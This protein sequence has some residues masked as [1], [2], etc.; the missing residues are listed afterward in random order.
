[1]QRRDDWPERLA[2]VIKA[3]IGRPFCWGEWDC[4]HFVDA[5][6]QAMTGVD[7]LPRVRGR[8]ANEFGAGRQ[9]RRFARDLAETCDQKFGDRVA[10]AYARRGDLVMHGGNLGVVVDHDAMFVTP[11]GVMR[12]AVA[13][14]DLAWRVA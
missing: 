8:Y 6:I 5:C 3:A 14:C 7:Q 1:M 4:V 9:I 10:V 13:R 2:E 11:E 12:I